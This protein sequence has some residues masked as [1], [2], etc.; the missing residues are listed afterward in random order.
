MSILRYF[1]FDSCLIANCL[2]GSKQISWDLGYPSRPN[3]KPLAKILAKWGY[4]C[5]DLN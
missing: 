4:Y 1:T 5:S 2:A 3:S